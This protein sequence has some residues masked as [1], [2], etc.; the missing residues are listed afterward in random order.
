MNI[1]HNP[2][3]PNG[4]IAFF[5]MRQTERGAGEVKQEAKFRGRGRGSCRLSI[6]FREGGGQEE[7]KKKG[8]GDWGSWP[9]KDVLQL[10]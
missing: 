5:M 4:L 6:C 1:Q 7:G 10:Y 8:G 9:E 2:T 3:G